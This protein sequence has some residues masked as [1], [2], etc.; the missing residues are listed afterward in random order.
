SVQR[1][2]GPRQSRG[3]VPVD[4]AACH[5]EAKP[6]PLVPQRRE[7]AALY[8]QL[9]PLISCRWDRPHVENRSCADVWRDAPG[10]L[11]PKP[12]RTRGCQGYSVGCFSVRNPDVRS[13]KAWG[14]LCRIEL[15]VVE[16][17]SKAEWRRMNKTTPHR[18]GLPPDPRTISG[19]GNPWI[20][21]IICIDRIRPI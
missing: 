4:F 3:N 19:T 2:R 16:P 14:R 13:E 7:L 6:A 8:R 12:N 15:E 1:Q 11:R 9:D 10:G 17:S 21:A 18:E 20:A 5:R